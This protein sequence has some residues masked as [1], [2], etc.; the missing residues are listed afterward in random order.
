[1]DKMQILN[2]NNESRNISTDPTY[3]KDTRREHYEQLLW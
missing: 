3:I 2:I 1:M